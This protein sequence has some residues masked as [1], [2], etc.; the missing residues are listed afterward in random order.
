ML[1]IVLTAVG[2][3]LLFSGGLLFAEGRRRWLLAGAFG[4]LAAICLLIGK[5]TPWLIL[6]VVAI[7]AAVYFARQPAPARR[8]K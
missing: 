1:K 2:M 3:L 4:V 6:A 5:G 8:D 7:L